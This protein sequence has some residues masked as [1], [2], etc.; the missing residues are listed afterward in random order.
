[1]TLLRG[2]K[3]EGKGKEGEGGGRERREKRERGRG[4]GRGIGRENTQ[5]G[6]VHDTCLLFQHSESHFELKA[7]WSTYGIPK[8]P[9]LHTTSKKKQKT[10]NKKQKN[11][12]Q[13]DKKKSKGEGGK[14]GVTGVGE[15]IKA[16]AWTRSS[17]PLTS[18]FGR[19]K[20]SG[21]S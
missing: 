15:S 4:E 14:E 1:M 20:T 12:I 5:V 6:C 19:K 2:R 18:A 10:K 9:W 17:I 7:A 21:I 16:L 8:Q 11:N 13:T 3:R